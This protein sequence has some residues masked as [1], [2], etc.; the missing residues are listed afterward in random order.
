MRGVGDFG[1]RDEDVGVEDEEAVRA[2]ELKR[3]V[4]GG[5]VEVADEIDDVA[6]S[7]NVNVMGI[8]R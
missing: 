7:R 8:G 3:R 1:R 2:G 6:Y 5:K 4:F